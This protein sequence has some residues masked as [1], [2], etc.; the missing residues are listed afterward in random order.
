M[1]HEITSSQL[2]KLPFW[3]YIFV[4]LTL[5]ESV[6]HQ[7]WTS[8]HVTDLD[9]SHARNMNA[10]TSPTEQKLVILVIQH[11]GTLDWS[12]VYSFAHRQ[13]ESCTTFVSVCSSHYIHS[14]APSHQ[15]WRAF[16]WVDRWLSW[17]S[18]APNRG[19]LTC[20]LSVS[21]PKPALSCHLLHANHSD[22]SSLCQETVLEITIQYS[23]ALSQWQETG[24]YYE[25]EMIM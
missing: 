16:T 17:G 19:A 7:P 11:S 13:R 10:S 5:K 24:N 25:T 20:Q 8:P 14:A 9:Q 12:E 21:P 1:R 22:T 4:N 2:N 6:P 23:I 18:A 15:L 3:V